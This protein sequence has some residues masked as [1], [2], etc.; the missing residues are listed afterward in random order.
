MNRSK[1]T[2]IILV[3][4]SL[5]LIHCS[6]GTLSVNVDILSFFAEEDTQLEY[7]EDPVIPGF[8][9]EISIKSPIQIIPLDGDITAAGE[10]ERVYINVGIEIS[11]ETGEAEGEFRIFMCETGL[12]PFLTTPVIEEDVVITPDTTYILD[13]T[14]EGDDRLLQ[15]FKK[16][17]IYVAAEVYLYPGQLEDDIMGAMTMNELSAI[18]IVS[19]SF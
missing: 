9:P 8:G 4:S 5:F 17:E 12:D 19:S 14:M 1:V 11:N 7:G 15:L 13:I 2:V 18:V 6:K 3:L 16:E 10:V